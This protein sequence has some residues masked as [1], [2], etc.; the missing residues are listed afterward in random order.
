M[1]AGSW[2]GLSSLV[3]W[4]SMRCVV[5]CG[6][7]SFPCLV[8]LFADMRAWSLT[9]E[10]QTAVL[11]QSSSKITWQSTWPA[12]RISAG[13]VM[14]CVS[15]PIWLSL[16]TASEI[17][18]IHLPVVR[19][20]IPRSI[21]KN[22]YNE[23][24]PLYVLS[25]K[26]NPHFREALTPTSWRVFGG[27]V[28]YTK[29]TYSIPWVKKKLREKELDYSIRLKCI[30]SNDFINIVRLT[31]LHQILD[32]HPRSFKSWRKGIL[33]FWSFLRKQLEKFLLQPFI[34]HFAFT[35]T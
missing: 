33:F 6:S 13:D 35:Y 11:S 2:H 28:A 18:G 7:T 16:L 10:L 12:S 31:D 17:S 9:A 23:L 1:P 25:W 21:D 32:V 8:L 27:A 29:S 26:G 19:W 22:I 30:V 5:S 34:V 24:C 15:P 14:T 4:P 20:P 3:T